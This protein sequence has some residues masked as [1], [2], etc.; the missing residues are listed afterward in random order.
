MAR[1]LLGVNY[2]PRTS[3]MAMWSRFDA[4]EVDEDFAH[5]AAL[6]FDVVRF[7]LRWEAFQPG[8]DEI[9][10]DALHKFETLI[11]RAGARGLRVMP[12][13]FCG[14]M[15]G[16]NWMPEWTLETREVDSRFRIVTSEGVTRRAIA[17]FYTGELLEAQRT[18]VR[19]LGERV[20]D[21]PAILVWDLGN[22][23]SNMRAPASPHDAE[24]WSA[25]LTHDLFESSNLP[26][27]GGTHG[28]DLSEDRNIRLSSI[29]D[30]WK[31]ATMHGYAAYSAFARSPDDPEVVPFLF[32]LAETFSRKCVLFSEFGNPACPPGSREVGGVPCLDEEAMATYARAVLERLHARGALGAFWWCWTDYAAALAATPPFDEAPHELLFGIVRKDGTEKPVAKVLREFARQRRPLLEPA[33]AP[34]IDEAR[35]YE[36]LPRSLDAAYAQHCERYDPT[37]VKR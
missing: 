22:E 14:H 23:F 29:C 11:E 20:R 37:A 18:F 32:E 5:I 33:L 19:A 15:S 28:E 30:P 27:T 4:G 26:V 16:I 17:D 10:E 9:S 13:L 1:F 3:A 7:F 24:H 31:F 35:Y 34:R 6:G 8:P 25:A 36:S 2:W 21:H 12:T